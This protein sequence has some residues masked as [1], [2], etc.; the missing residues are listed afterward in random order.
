MGLKAIRRS[1]GELGRGAL[2]FVGKKAKL[3]GDGAQIEMEGDTTRTRRWHGPRGFFVPDG[4]SRAI[5]HRVMKA[6]SR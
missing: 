5:F 3:G 6:E 2:A 4:G 1:G